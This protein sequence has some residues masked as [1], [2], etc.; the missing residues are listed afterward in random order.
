MGKE[1]GIL[2]KLTK[3]RANLLPYVLYVLW[4][5]R[6]LNK[7]V[8]T[9]LDV[10]CGQGVAARSGIRPRKFFTVGAEIFLPDLRVA[11]KNR[12]HDDFVLCD[13][14]SLPFQRKSFD[15]VLCMEMLEHVDKEEGLRLLRDIEEIAVRKVILSTPA[16]FL[17]TGPEP[18][19]TPYLH[20]NPQQGHRAGWEPNELRALG[21]KVYCND[22]LY[23]IEEFLTSHHRTWSWMLSIIIFPL[24]R[25]INWISPKFG[26]HPF[27]VKEMLK[28]YE[29][30]L[31]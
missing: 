28:V 12:T 25:S 6:E 20:D 5:P 21:Y 29:K 2:S 7:E 9:I 18:E 16:G 3:V 14:R 13:A 8:K 24:V 10:G 31:L 22:Y 30:V 27:C 17:Y 11:K 4:V 19:T 23:K 1:S 26:C 15:V